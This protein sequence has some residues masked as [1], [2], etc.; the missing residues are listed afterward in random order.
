MILPT[1]A[2]TDRIL[3][4][5]SKVSVT[6]WGFGGAAIAGLYSPVSDD[7]ARQ[8][9]EAAWGAGVRYFE[10]VPHYGTGLSEMRL[11]EVLRIAVRT[12]QDH[13]LR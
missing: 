6:A 4:G 3:L 7:D 5:H 12:D 9:I 2:P 10:T 11:G 8:A 1:P 13:Y